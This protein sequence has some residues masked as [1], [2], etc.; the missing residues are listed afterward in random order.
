MSS[1]TFEPLK[2]I[3]ASPY[4]YDYF[5]YLIITSKFDLRNKNSSRLSLTNDHNYKY[6][7]L[8]TQKIVD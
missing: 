8:N 7:A 2:K 4:P 6:F 5:S 3:I 1:V